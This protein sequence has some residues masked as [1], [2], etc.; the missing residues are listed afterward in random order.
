MKKENFKSVA[1]TTKEKTEEKIIYLLDDGEEKYYKLLG[2]AYGVNFYHCF[3]LGM[4]HKEN[5][6]NRV[7]AYKISADRDQV[8]II[9]KATGEKYVAIEFYELNS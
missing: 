2:S 7:F 1:L 8:D 9:E 5:F 3:A 4:K 6:W